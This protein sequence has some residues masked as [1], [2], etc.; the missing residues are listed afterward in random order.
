MPACLTHIPYEEALRRTASQ[1]R[2]LLLG[3]GFSIIAHPRFRYDDLADEAMKLNPNLKAAFAAAGTKNFEV[4]LQALQGQP[5][6]LRA[7]RTGLLKA[8]TK[9]HPYRIDMI[10]DAEY[11]ACADFLEPFVGLN[12]E[13]LRGWIFTTNYDLLLYWALVKGAARLDCQDGFFDGGQWEAVRLAASSVFYL[14]G[15]LHIFSERITPRYVEHRKLLWRPS[16]PLVRQVRRR[17]EQGAYPVFISEAS[18][19]DKLRRLRHSEYLNAVR[20]RFAKACREEGAALFTVGH[21]LAEEDDHI[22]SQIGGGKITN[23]YVGVFSDWDRERADKLARE[24][25]SARP[26]EVFTFNTS[27]CSIWTPKDRRRAG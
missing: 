22:V 16:F 3:N 4:A 7:V 23:V 12:R 6:Q 5:E 8:I 15:A 9:V 27:E 26:V 18:P 13:E 11:E 24:W 21:S 2:H 19:R 20:R 1:R 10:D 25:R 14:H 17:L